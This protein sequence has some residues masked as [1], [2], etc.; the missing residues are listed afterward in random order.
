MMLVNEVCVAH[1]EKFIFMMDD[2]ASCIAEFF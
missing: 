2:D 1:E